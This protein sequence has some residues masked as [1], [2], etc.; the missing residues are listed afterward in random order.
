VSPPDAPRIGMGWE[1]FP[2]HSRPD[3]PD[4][5]NVGYG[6]PVTIVETRP[7]WWHI[8]VSWSDGSRLD[9]WTP[10]RA[11]ASYYEDAGGSV[12]G[13]FHG[14]I[15]GGVVDGPILE[16]ALLHAGAAIAAAPAG[17]P[18]A[19]AAHELEVEVVVMNAYQA[20]HDRRSDE[21]LE[22][23]KAPGLLPPPSGFLHLEH[24]WVQ[25]RDLTLSGSRGDP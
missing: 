5:F 10:E 1:P 8:V 2:V 9:G 4:V 19:R 17:P 16:R 6:G 25:R 13:G 7:G 14:G 12:G 15:S 3:G 24:T 11:S 20:P 21:W 23:A 22:V 18:W